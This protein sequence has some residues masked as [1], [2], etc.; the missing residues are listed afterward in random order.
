MVTFSFTIEFIRQTYAKS[1]YSN[2]T[3][4]LGW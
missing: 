3:A 2:Q 1:C 4:N